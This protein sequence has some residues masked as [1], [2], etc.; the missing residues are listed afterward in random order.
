MRQYRA[1]IEKEEMERQKSREKV[2]NLE[3][4]W[5]LLR[6]C[7]DF[8][9]EYSKEWKEHEELRRMRNLEEGR[10]QERLKIA[11]YKKGKVRDEQLQK[12]IT[13]VLTALPRKEK[14]NY[15]A[16]EERERKLELKTIKENMWKK[17]RKRRENTIPRGKGGNQV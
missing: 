6:L 10:K 2:N 16:E 7:S 13:N 1:E 8:I 14:D 5:E 11:A 9:R 17:W 15:L 3:K 12:K 4:S